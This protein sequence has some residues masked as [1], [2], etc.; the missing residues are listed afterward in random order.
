[1]HEAGEDDLAG[2]SGHILVNHDCK[3]SVF[4][5]GLYV[6]LKGSG[7]PNTVAAS[8]NPSF[9]GPTLSLQK[10][11]SWVERVR[12]R[13]SEVEAGSGGDGPVDETAVSCQTEPLVAIILGK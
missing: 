1:M 3:S 10:R 13:Q 5:A 2:G 7:A 11:T 4:M 12:S 8:G 9:A 6:K